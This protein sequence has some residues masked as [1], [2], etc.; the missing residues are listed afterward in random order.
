[1]KKLAIALLA[2]LLLVVAPLKTAADT[3]RWTET[4]EVVLQW[5]G[6]R[7]VDF[8]VV[9]D[10]DLNMVNGAFMPP[11]TYCWWTYCYVVPQASIVIYAGAD[12]PELILTYV[13]LHE[14]G[15]YLQWRALGADR[16]SVDG[17]A[18]EWDADVFA[19][20]AACSLGYDGIALIRAFEAWVFVHYGY[21]GDP[22]HGLMADRVANAAARAISCVRYAEAP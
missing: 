17:V 3:A 4:A 15:H 2:V 8:T 10:P 1:M 21:E 5:A 11:G 18:L 7:D 13:L 12:V 22:E 14:V 9:E 6:V 19:V 20:N 16:F